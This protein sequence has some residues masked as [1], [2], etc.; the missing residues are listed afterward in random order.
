MILP[1]GTSDVPAGKIAL[2]CVRGMKSQKP[3]FTKM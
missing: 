2:R 1:D 3:P